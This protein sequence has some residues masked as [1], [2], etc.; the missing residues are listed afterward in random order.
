MEHSHDS[1]YSDIVNKLTE[2]M[3][4]LGSIGSPPSVIA[5]TIH[6]A[7]RARRPKTR[8]AAGKYANLI[9]LR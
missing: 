5:D 9:L 8:Y 2:M 1:A 4:R 7:I 6:K 3:S